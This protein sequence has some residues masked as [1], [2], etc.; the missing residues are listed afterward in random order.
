MRGTLDV[1][2]DHVP[3]IL[4]AARL[5][6]PDGTLVFCTNLR[7]FTLDAAAMPGLAFEAIT[8]RTIPKDFAG[9]P[10]IHSCWLVRAR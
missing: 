1:Q 10:R 5:L 2:R 4:D 3:L 7:R 9:N 6:E 8:R